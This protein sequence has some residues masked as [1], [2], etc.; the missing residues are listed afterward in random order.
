MKDVG[1]W[2]SYKRSLT[3]PELQKLIDTAIVTERK[4]RGNFDDTG[5]RKEEGEERRKLHTQA[6][7]NPC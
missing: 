6:T 5:K 3:V 2:R 4:E 7:D 1:G